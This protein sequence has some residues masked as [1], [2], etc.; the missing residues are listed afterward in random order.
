LNGSARA[1]AARVAELGGSIESLHEGAGVAVINGLS[2]AAA[3]E[4]GRTAG[5]SE[6]VADVEIQAVAPAAT[7]LQDAQATITSQSNPAAGIFASWAWNQRTIGADHAWAAGK[8]GSA[9]VSVAILDSGIDYN[10]LDLNG[11][12]DLSRSVS[13]VP[14]DDAILAANRPGRHVVSDLNGHGTNVAQTVSSIATVFPG[15]A[16]HVQLLGVK[17]LGRTGSGPFSGLI[18]GLLYA[19]DAGADVVNMSLGAAF[20]RTAGGSLIS[21]LNRVSNYLRKQGVVV[22]VAA[23]NESWDLDHANHNADDEGD[24]L[25]AN[26]YAVFCDAV[27]VICVSATGPTSS[28][29]LFEGPWQDPTA[30]ASYSNYG[31]SAVTVAAPGGT[32]SGFVWSMCP[33][34]LAQRTSGGTFVFPCSSGFVILGFAGTSQAT[35][36]VAGLAALLVSE[37]GANNPVAIKQAIIRSADDLGQPGTDP[38]YGKGFINVKIA[39]GL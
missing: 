2:A 11:L 37:L 5:V 9:S 36:H 7:I 35:P 19:A 10:S 33:K 31:R 20:A 4:L 38:F 39:L 6:L 12:V 32:G 30:F 34:D 16:S 29:D 26:L 13:F 23:G 14:S 22:V 8:L 1:F 15:V 18:N 28:D 3:A 17:V 27:H 25:P 21:L 24:P